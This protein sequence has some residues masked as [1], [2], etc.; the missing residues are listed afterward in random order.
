MDKHQ[1]ATSMNMSDTKELKGVERVKE[2]VKV[3]HKE[4]TIPVH[5]QPV[6]K[7]TGLTGSQTGTKAENVE[8]PG[9]EEGEDEL[10]ALLDL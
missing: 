1:S 7:E 8:S 4:S 9:R 2:E 5:R 3:E 10:D 6:S